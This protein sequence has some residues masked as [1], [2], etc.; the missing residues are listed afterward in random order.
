[1][2][3][4]PNRSSVERAASDKSGM[5]LFPVARRLSPFARPVAAMAWEAYPPVAILVVALLVGAGCK[6]GDDVRTGDELQ[7]DSNVISAIDGTATLASADVETELATLAFPSELPTIGTAAARAT[8]RHGKDQVDLFNLSKTKWP[9]VRVWLNGE[10]STLVQ[11]LESGKLQRLRFASFLNADGK[12]FP[13][14]NR[15]VRVERV[16]MQT[17]D[18]L[19]RV[20]FGIGR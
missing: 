5:S 3:N 18:E 15:T 14:D 7:D 17:G 4:E 10:Y 6:S 8:I 11:D 16:E 2:G 19:A 1:M 20:R 12:P 13:S 9:R